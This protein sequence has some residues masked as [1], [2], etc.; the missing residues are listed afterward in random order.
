MRLQGIVKMQTLYQEGRGK[1]TQRVH[2]EKTLRWAG[3]MAGGEGF[4]K[5]VIMKNPKEVDTNIP[6]RMVAP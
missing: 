3:V 1:Y 5:E 6:Q 4:L 2:T